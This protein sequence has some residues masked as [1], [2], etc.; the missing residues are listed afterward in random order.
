MMKRQIFFAI[1]VLTVPMAMAD[2]VGYWTFNE[3]SGSSV[4]DSSGNGMN[5]FLYSANGTNYPQWIAGYNGGALRFNFNTTGSTN[6]N[7]VAIDPNVMDPNVVDPNLPGLTSLSD[8]FTFSM[9]VRR[10]TLDYSIFPR[11]VHTSA[12]D[13]Q[14]ALDPAA[15]PGSVDAHDYFGW[16]GVGGNRFSI[17]VE[18]TAQKT[19]GNWYHL[20]VV[21]DG[22]HIQKYINGV[23]VYSGSTP[24]IEMPFATA[25][26]IIGSKLDN[27]QYFTGALDDVAVWSGGYLPAEEVV[28]LA[29]NT[30]TPLSVVESGGIV[31]VSYY[32]ETALYTPGTIAALNPDMIQLTNIE[33][34]QVVYN[35]FWVLPEPNS[36][37]DYKPFAW[38]VKD[39][40]TYADIPADI[41]RYGVEWVDQSWNGRESDMA[42][43]AAY[44]TP[45]LIYGQENTWYQIYNPGGY[46]WE[47]KPYFRTNIRVAAIHANGAGVRVTIYSRSS[48]AIPDPNNHDTL[49][50]YLGEVVC[51]LDAGDRVWQHYEFTLPKSASTATNPLWFE[52]AIVGGT[53]DTVLYI[54][55]FRPVSDRYVTFR[56]T[57]LSENS[58]IDE[59]DIELLAENWLDSVNTTLVDPRDG[60]LL[61]NSDFTADLAQVLT[62][63]DSTVKNP[64]GWMFTG[65]GNYGVRNTSKLGRT[66][67]H[68]TQTMNNPVGGNV[69][70]YMTDMVTAPD[71]DMYVDDPNGVLEQ[72]ASATAVSGQTYYAMGYVMAGG[73]ESGLESGE[74]RGW[75]DTA[76]MEIAVDGV[77]KTTFSRKLSRGVWRALYGTYTAVPADAGK[78][79]SI[80]F[81]Y[82]NTYTH[83]Y[84]QSGTMNVGYAYLGTTVPAEWPEKRGNL[85]TNGSFEDLSAVQSFDTAYGTT[86][87][88]S[89]TASDNAGAWFASGM[90]MTSIIPGWIYEVTGG[91]DLNNQG[92][93][94]STGYYSAP[95]PSP[96]F[97]DIV[98][99]GSGTMVYG[100][101]VGALTAGATYYLDTACGV[102]IEPAVWGSATV[103]WPSPAPT[104]HVELW[105]I[106]AGVTDPAVIHT[107]VATS[108]AGYVKLAYADVVSTGDIKANND[109]W[110]IIGTSYTA[111]S[112]DTNVYVRIY[113]TNAVTVSPDYHPSFVFSDAYLSTQKRLI[114]G[115]SLINSISAGVAADLMVPYDCYQAFLM[116]Y[117]APAVGDINGDCTVNLSDFA[118]IASQWLEAGIA[119]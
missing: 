58:V 51:P 43:V 19:L 108:A 72:T 118:L 41:S 4:T 71:F 13:I 112:A 7:H 106:P 45:G 35:G 28:K 80:R 76:T 16:T 69:S 15:G 34:N 92:G 82:A 64:A 47:D 95:I 57:D 85:L 77:V 33:N 54:D 75:K 49:L 88:N 10:D 84:V 23:E 99:Y 65:T 53:E 50:T 117:T 40:T 2:L 38:K 115:G 3:G 22:V 29:N 109:K 96:G 93:I 5:G 31:P 32:L 63:G 56:S 11:L 61:F 67:W 101:I 87:Y 42:V 21:C 114:A 24:G 98:I 17:G 37:L 74:W 48:S 94:F 27:S 105:R 102:L 6:S 30:A 55:N 25:N 78:P 1:L 91:Y 26:F 90:P 39:E 52:M 18:D 113:G 70:A 107:G 104:L 119:F 20:A 8:V 86:Y 60:G 46:S 12:Y 89:L 100:Q 116:G 73:D 36:R 14:L 97:N 110:Q 68:Y 62:P 83:Y 59:P 66:G 79:I 44:I 111:T 81:S 103:T 9:W